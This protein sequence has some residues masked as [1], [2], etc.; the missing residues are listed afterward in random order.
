[1]LDIFKLVLSSVHS[2]PP[3]LR[4][5][6]VLLFFTTAI[7]GTVAFKHWLENR[8]TN[9][10]TDLW[11]C[12]PVELAVVQVVLWGIWG[13]ASLSS[14][15]VIED[16]RPKPVAS[17]AA[18][19][20]AVGGHAPMALAKAHAR[21]KRDAHSSALSPRKAP[22][23]QEAGAGRGTDAM[24]AGEVVPPA[25]PAP[26]RSRARGGKAAAPVE[27]RSL[28]PE[29]AVAPPEL[30]TGS[31]PHPA[32]GLASRVDSTAPV[33]PPLAPVEATADGSDLTQGTRRTHAE[34]FRPG[35]RLK[36]KARVHSPAP[37]SAVV[38]AAAPPPSAEP[39]AVAEEPAAPA[40]ELV[41][42][43]ARRAG[44]LKAAL[45]EPLRRLQ[46]E[47]RSLRAAAD[48]A[49]DGAARPSASARQREISPAAVPDPAVGAAPESRS[50]AAPV[51]SPVPVAPPAAPPAPAQTTDSAAAAASPAPAA[52]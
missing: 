11:A 16:G 42:A 14:V 52:H 13:T 9:K 26:V 27:A 36:R 48:A 50:E 40:R 2:L 33:A 44:G 45:T 21:S 4:Y 19:P 7:V 37:E 38:E 34:P 8:K 39:P 1:M 32:G 23:I 49:A 10:D 47:V 6:F 12:M 15:Y 20:A 43:P 5:S 28:S 30:A 41:P 29:N 3:V 25:R 35:K 22:A 24:L 51:G 31:P 17:A 46:A 18:S